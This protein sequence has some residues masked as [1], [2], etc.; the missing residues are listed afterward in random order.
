[1]TSFGGP[2]A[3]AAFAPGGAA[4]LVNRG[5]EAFALP[6]PAP[7]SAAN[8]DDIRTGAITSKGPDDNN[9]LDS[10]LTKSM[11]YML[12]EQTRDVRQDNEQ[13]RLE[14]AQLRTLRDQSDRQLREMRAAMQE[15][16]NAQRESA[17]Q[18]HALMALFH[19]ASPSHAPLQEPLL[20]RMALGRTDLS[21]ELIEALPFLGGCSASESIVYDLR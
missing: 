17:T 7:S 16:A 1:L 3:L 18:L 19:Q 9:Q 2:P 21:E 6:P 10:A 8:A 13:L 20:Q 4:A 14:V 15:M 11:L 12:M 5:A